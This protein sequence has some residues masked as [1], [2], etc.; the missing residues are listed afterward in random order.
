MEGIT[1]AQ[2][3]RS[4][5]A[6]PRGTKS[7]HRLQGRWY[8]GECKHWLRKVTENLPRRGAQRC[9]H[10]RCNR[11]GRLTCERGQRPLGTKQDGRVGTGAKAVVF[12]SLK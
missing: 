10:Y 11:K 4:N 6:S 2:T 7:A 8:R 5:H 12:K 9:R 3:Y 1:Q